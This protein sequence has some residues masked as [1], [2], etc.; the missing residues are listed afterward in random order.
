MRRVPLA[1]VCAALGW[2]A[3]PLPAQDVAWTVSVLTSLPGG[4]DAWELATGSYE[5][6]V[7]T[8]RAA[9][10]RLALQVAPVGDDVACESTIGLLARKMEGTRVVDDPLYLPS[11]YY[12]HALVANDSVTHACLFVLSGKTWLVIIGGDTKSD[13]PAIAKALASVA[14]ALR[15]QSAQPSVPVRLA[16]S[17]VAF[18]ITPAGW[19]WLTGGLDQP[20]DIGIALSATGEGERGLSMAILGLTPDRLD[21]CVWAASMVKMD[22]MQGGGWFPNGYSQYWGKRGSS[23]AVACLVRRGLTYLVVVK[24]NLDDTAT[25]TEAARI[26]TLL[27]DAS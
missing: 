3:A 18:T 9:G 2:S 21:D 16:N 1:L 20:G 11:S 27:R 24:G 17:A 14:T 23:A 12:P 13:G 19:R 10:K 7:F 25:R 8:R 4:A 22:A 6:F 15:T 26:L 5:S